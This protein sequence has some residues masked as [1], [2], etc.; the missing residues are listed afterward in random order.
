[1]NSKRNI[2]KLGR[3]KSHRESLKKNLLTSLVLYEHVT[4]TKARAK[5]ILP[6]FDRLI[7]D[8]KSQDYP[9]QRKLTQ[10]LFDENAIRKVNEVLV[11]R[12]KDETSGFVQMFKLGRRKGDNAEMVKLMVKGYEY[13]DIG[14]KQAPKKKEKKAEAD[15]KSNVR[16]NADMEKG[17][18]V[19]ESA[20]TNTRSRSGI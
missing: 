12:F 9:A 5:A 19:K 3:K 15:N 11:D 4:T 18:Q 17:S 16:A 6:I 2:H 13:K 1:M 10:T 7:A 8:A 14:K 20:P